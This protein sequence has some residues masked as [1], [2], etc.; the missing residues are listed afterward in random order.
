MIDF[1]FIINFIIKNFRWLF[2]LGI[3]VGIIYFFWDNLEYL[4]DAQQ[5]QREFFY[6][7]HK[8]R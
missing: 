5:G 8:N 3:F 4:Y 2:I 6:V 1:Y 7:Y